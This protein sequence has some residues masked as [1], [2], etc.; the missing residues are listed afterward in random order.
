MRV[1]LARDLDELLEVLDAA[2]RLDRAL[3][4]ER[5]EVARLAQH[6]LEQVA[7]RRAGLGALAQALASSP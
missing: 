7:D 4:L 2:L 6:L 5:V 1:V 3:G